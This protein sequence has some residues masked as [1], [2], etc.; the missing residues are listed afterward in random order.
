MKRLF[1]L[2]LLLPLVVF[3]QTVPNGTITQGQVW[4]PAQWNAAWQ[5]K[6]DLTTNINFQKITA[7]A[8]QTVFNLSSAPAVFVALDGVVL[9]PVTD[10]TVSGT[11]VTLTNGAL[12][13]QVLMVR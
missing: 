9:A 10:Y 2:L 13:G 12:A 5:A 4:T 7:T 6:A 1:A 11:T 3:A 8:S